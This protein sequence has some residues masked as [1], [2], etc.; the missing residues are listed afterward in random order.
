M[1][2]I[3]IIYDIMSGALLVVKRLI[4]KERETKK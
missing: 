4:K 1:M 3:R 2:C